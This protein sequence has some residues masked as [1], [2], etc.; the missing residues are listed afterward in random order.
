MNLSE[1]IQLIE[2]EYNCFTGPARGYFELPMDVV[3]PEPNYTYPQVLR[4][5][6]ST[7]SRAVRGSGEEAEQ[8]LTYWVAT[9]LLAKL[10][11]EQRADR[12]VCLIWRHKPV[13][14]EFIGPRGETC[15]SIRLRLAIPGIDLS[16]LIV[17][18]GEP[19]PWL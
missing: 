17:K 14:M 18:E 2:H 11:K 9:K 10:T 19:P 15:L 16:D 13:L 1:L 3:P 8:L 6:Y 7:L 4:V 12:A 5:V